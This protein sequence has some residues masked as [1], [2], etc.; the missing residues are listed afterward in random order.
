M[1]K[2]VA[3]TTP[4]AAFMPVGE[5][6][7]ASWERTKLS[8]KNLLVIFLLI[9]AVSFALMFV[10]GLLLLGGGAMSMLQSGA[11][12]SEMLAQSVGTLLPFAS[13][14]FVIYAV[15]MMIL[16]SVAGV[17]MI[18]AVARAEEKPKIGELMSTGLKLFVP[19][20]LTSLIVTFLVIGGIF[21]LVIPG[22]IIAVFMSFVSYEVILGK[23]K[24]LAAMESSASLIGQNFGALFVRYLVILGIAIGISLIEGILRGILGDSALSGLVGL[25]SFVVQIAF[26]IFT[27]SYSY[28]L[29]KEATAAADKNKPASMTWMWIVSIIGWVIGVFM[30]IAAIGSIAAMMRSGALEQLM[31]GSVSPMNNSMM[32]E[33]GTTLDSMEMYDPEMMMLNE[34]EEGMYDAD[35]LIEQYGSELTDEEKQI[36]RDT[37]NGIELE[38]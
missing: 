14:L 15:A 4:P 33:D 21:L 10:L 26:S 18:L 9:Y 29:Y 11:N 2:A 12:F 6:I 3:T 25:V 22:I 28:M 30:M 38:Q 13:V 20:F 35:M 27:I 19:L 34:G 1:A 8:W 32:M 36:L 16:G 24:Y 17:A 37:I 7:K 31:Q 5:L 23:K